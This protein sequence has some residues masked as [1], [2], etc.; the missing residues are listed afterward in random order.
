MSRDVSGVFA[1]ID[2]LDPDRFVANLT[3][4][5]KF[6]FGNAEDLTGREA[7][8]SA[9]AGFFSTIDGLTHHIK[10]SWDHGD[11]TIVQI[12]VDYQR[13]DGKVVTVPNADILV[14]QGDLVCNWQIYIDITPVYA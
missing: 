10:N 8:K 7:I 14:Y 13:Q 5:A 1:A 2:S 11:T 12:D 9:V 6:R 3:P 4:D